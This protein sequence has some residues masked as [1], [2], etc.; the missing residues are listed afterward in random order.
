MRARER[1]ATVLADSAWTRIDSATEQP[2]A[3][4][5]RES[6]LAHAR[7]TM[8]EQSARQ[9]IATDGVI[10]SGA[11]VR[12]TVEGKKRHARK[13]RVDG[14]SAQFMTTG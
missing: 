9:R 13:V 4:P 6:L 1:V 3:D 10:D 8:Q 12:V 5:E 7:R 11:N 14:G 2:L